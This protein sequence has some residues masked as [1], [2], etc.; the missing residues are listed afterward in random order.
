MSFNS[1]PR[2]EAGSYSDIPDPDIFIDDLAD[3][4]TTFSTRVEA[5]G[6][7][8]NRGLTDNTLPKRKAGSAD[9][10]ERLESILP[11]IK[12]LQEYRNLTVC[13][14]YTWLSMST[15]QD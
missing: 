8:L 2:L 13:F 3:D 1:G 10:R 14:V 11:R 6:N 15:T 5:F 9:L 12:Q 7:V 4:V